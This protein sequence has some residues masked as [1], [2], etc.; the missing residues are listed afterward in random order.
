MYIHIYKW[1]LLTKYL[2]SRGE[3]LNIIALAQSGL[4]VSNLQ[5]E[6]ISFISLRYFRVYKY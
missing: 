5:L 6:I 2:F 4:V 3:G 1:S